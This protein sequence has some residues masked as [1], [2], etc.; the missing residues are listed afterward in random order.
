M[1]VLIILQVAIQTFASAA[2]ISVSRYDPVPT[3][4]A[5]PIST[6]PGYRLQSF[7]DG[8]YMVTDGLYQ[9][10]F[11]VASE[12]VVVVDAPPSIGENVLR[13]IRNVTMKPISHVV[14]SHHHAD[15]ISGAYLYGPPSD[16]DF[17]AHRLTAEELA[18]SPD[19]H[20]PAPT[21][22]FDSSYTLNVGNQTLQLDYRGPNHDP[23]NIFIYAPTQKILMLGTY[24]YS[25][26]QR[27]MIVS[28]GH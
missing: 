22:T 23:G 1:L 6:P 13:A 2:T 18:Q 26:S 11:F 12:S 16:V 25:L 4:A 10:L 24:E 19:N 7:G 3:T 17:I 20:R 28:L 9:N 5:G 27:H 15:H 21:I 14:Y 8:A